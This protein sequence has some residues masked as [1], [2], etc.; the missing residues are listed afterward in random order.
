MMRILHVTPSYKPAFRYGGPTFSVSCLAE[1]QAKAGAE[2]W[3][4]TTTANGEEE[5]PVSRGVPIEVEGVQVVYFSRWT[6]DHG[7]FC[8][9][10]WWAVWRQGR[11]FDVVHV[12]SWWNWVAFGAVLI[13][14]LRGLR[15]VFSPH[16][17]LS[18][19]TLRH[20]LKRWFQRILGRWLLARALWHATSRLEERE[21]QVHKPPNPTICVPNITPFPDT[22][23]IQAPAP[24]AALRLLYLSR[25]DPKKGLDFLLNVLAEIKG[26]CPWQ[27]T[28]VGDASNP[29]GREMRK[30]A[31]RLGLK[32][33]VVWHGWASGEEKWNLLAWSDLLLLPSQNENFAIVVLEALAVGTAVLVSD[34][35]GL[36]DYVHEKDL[37]WCAPLDEEAWRLALKAAMSDD[38]KRRRIRREAPIQVRRDF[39]PETLV[40]RY[41]EVYRRPSVQVIFRKPAHSGH[42]SIERSFSAFWPYLSEDSAGVYVRRVVAR[43]P[44][45]GLLPRLRIGLQ[46]LFL[47]ADVFHISG[48]IH[49]A[50]LFLSGRKTLLTI[51]DCGFMQ[52]PQPWKRFVLSRLWLRWPVRHCRHVVAVSEA[53][54]ADIV[55]YTGC[56]EAKVSVIPS[57]I[58]SYFAPIPKPFEV[59][60]PRILHIGSAPNKNLRRHI[61]ALEGIRCVLHIVGRIGREERRL[62]ERCGVVYECTPDL[63]DAGVLQAYAY[64]DLLLFASTSEGFGMPIIEAQ[65]V[66]RPVV[67]SNC[68]SMPEVAG[69]EG[70]CLVDPFDVASIRRGVLRILEDADYRET[71]VERGFENARRFQP[72]AIARAYCALYR[73]FLQPVGTPIHPSPE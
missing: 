50:A 27:L 11:D 25:F 6:G 22:T 56:A 13:G 44:S 9:A 31:E 17:M 7:H 4:F 26:G 48:D 2:V 68:S 63:D 19:Y 61:E 49:F 69:V 40:W 57:A 45:R 30:L 24:R 34:R 36:C 42:Y 8:P 58:P 73:A 60:R 72:Q 47:R 71:L 62:L 43:A 28:V 10:L 15:M 16:G 14:R 67:T 59:A 18:P 12:H 21:L 52:H 51:H 66:G 29:F 64:C 41:L 38:A 46:M 35:V 5:L 70:A 20:S 33:R 65:T 39:D 37:G 23:A 53:T 3:V 1:Q 32:D 54:K 55:R